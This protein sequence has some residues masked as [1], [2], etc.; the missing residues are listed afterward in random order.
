MV[1]RTPKAG[2]TRLFTGND[3]TDNVL[4]AGVVGLGV[5]IGGVLLTQAFLDSQ[6]PRCKRDTD[7]MGRILGLGGGDYRDCEPKYRPGRPH[8]HPGGYREPA[9]RPQRPYR[10]HHGYREPEYHRPSSYRPSSY[11]KP[12]REEYRPVSSYKEPHREE[13]RPVSSYKEPHRDDYRRPV[14]SS[15][16]EPHRDEY[17]PVPHRDDYRRPSSSY[18]QPH[19]HEDDDYTTRR[20]IAVY[21]PTTTRRPPY[22]DDFDRQRNDDSP[23]RGRTTAV[24]EDGEPDKKKPEESNTGKVRFVDE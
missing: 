10:P 4:A 13:Y 2:E 15:Y 5:G 19:R 21:R 7:V 9:Y 8:H 23:F 11:Q 17:R 1:S 18:K 3:Q 16:R 22:Y 12:H 24:S 6:K 14:S 20:P